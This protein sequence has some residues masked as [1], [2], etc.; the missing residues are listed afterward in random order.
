MSH[1]AVAVDLGRFLERALLPDGWQVVHESS[2]TSTNDLARAAARRGWPD[3][4]AFVADYQ[5]AGRGRHGRSWTAPPGSGLL[6]SVLLR[7]SGVAP[8]AY[9]MLASLAV[10]EAVERLLALE[11][12]IKWPNDMMLAGKKAAGILAEATDDGA[13]RTVV[14]GI[15]INVNVDQATLAGLPNATSLAL[16]AGR[17]VHRG[18]LLVVMLERMDVWLK[19]PAERL[20]T[21]LWP[22]WNERLWGVSQ[23]VRVREQGEEIEGVILGSASDGTL[24]VRTAEGATRRIVAGELLP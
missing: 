12:A 1:P 18:E 11:P 15:G 23:R 7:R 13:E 17:P 2:V 14:V 24:L 20:S 19:L 10:C 21:A 9:T 22:A 4:S 16:E 3:R 8:H 5:T 6:V